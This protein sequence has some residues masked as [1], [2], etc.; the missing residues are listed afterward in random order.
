MAIDPSAENP[1]ISNIEIFL[2]GEKRNEYKRRLG[3]M[4]K[5]PFHYDH[6]FY[7]AL[8]RLGYPIKFEE[9]SAENAYGKEYE[10]SMVVFTKS[11]KDAQVID[12]IHQKYEKTALAIMIHG[13]YLR[14]PGSFLAWSKDEID[15]AVHRR[16]L[17]YK[18][19]DPN[20]TFDRALAQRCFMTA[21]DRKR[22]EGEVYDDEIN[23]YYEEMVRAGV[24][25]IGY[26]ELQGLAL[27]EI[28]LLTTPAS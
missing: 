23:E 26:P 3:Q 6:I 7:S 2:R 11:E 5:D 10:D 18:S 25:P 13:V 1:L 21:F 8:A 20:L 9:G 19:I 4:F 16:F 12:D 14:V 24:E 22:A 28:R 15:T 27:E 17:M